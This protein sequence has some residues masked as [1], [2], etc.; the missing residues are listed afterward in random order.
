MR[1]EW[2]KDEKRLNGYVAESIRYRYIM[3]VPRSGRV[4]LGV[5]Y[6]TDD[7]VKAKP[8][9]QRSCTS[10]AQAERIAQRF[11]NHRHPRKLR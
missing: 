3:I 4:V 9:D 6:A 5:Q 10:R 7:A 2:Q 8:I 1:L 11:E